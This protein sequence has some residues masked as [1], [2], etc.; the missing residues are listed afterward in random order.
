MESIFTSRRHLF[1]GTFSSKLIY[2]V[3]ILSL[4]NLVALIIIWDKADKAQIAASSATRGP[5][6][7]QGPQG[8]QGEP[9]IQGIQGVQGPQGEPGP[10]GLT[11][12]AGSKGA[13]GEPGPQGPVCTDCIRKGGVDLTNN[14]L[15]ALKNFTLSGNTVQVGNLQSTGRFTFNEMKANGTARVVS[16]IENEGNMLETD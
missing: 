9:G 3:G 13:Q 8:P 7:P 15:D 5:E 14:T 11:G 4:L 2:I 16:R 6:G 10:R 1:G 12:A